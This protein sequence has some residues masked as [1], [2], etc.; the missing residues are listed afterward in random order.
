[1][2]KGPRGNAYPASARVEKHKPEAWLK[3][4]L[5]AYRAPVRAS[6]LGPISRCLK[7]S[8]NV[9][10]HTRALGADS[11]CPSLWTQITPVILH[12][13]IKGSS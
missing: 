10:D 5:N 4:W 11:F 9:S 6:G 2:K 13:V 7:L 3:Q 12:R 8:L 1:M